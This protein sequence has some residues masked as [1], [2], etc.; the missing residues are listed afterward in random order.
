M[1]K[2]IRLLVTREGAERRRENQANKNFYYSCIFDILKDRY[3]PQEN[4]AELNLFK[5]KIVRIYSKQVQ[6]LT[7][8]MGEGGIFQKKQPSL[9]QLLQAHT[10]LKSH[11]IARVFDGNGS[12]RR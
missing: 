3:L 11:L 8:Q 9:F 7:E 1:S 4:M 5:A 12:M 6:T 2:N 10:R